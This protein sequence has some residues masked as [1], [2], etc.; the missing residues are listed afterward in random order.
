MN[1]LKKDWKSTYG[2]GHILVTVKCLLIYPNPESALDEEAGKLLLEDYNSYCERAKLITS[3]H[4]TPKVRARALLHPGPC[5]E[6]HVQVRPAEFNTPSRSDTPSEPSTSSAKPAPAAPSPATPSTST[7]PA[8][9]TSATA[10]TATT[11]SAGAAPS[12]P[13]SPPVSSSQPLHPST[14]NTY[15]TSPS[16]SSLSSEKGTS[17]PKERHVSPSPLGTADS[18]VA[19][20]VHATGGGGGGGTKAVKRAAVAAGAGGEKRKKALKRL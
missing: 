5:P 9:T 10:K 3:V 7:H 14:P 17:A 19:V 13:T 4:A 1:T 6:G 11:A 12:K 16:A 2:I 8:P 18:N 15:S 20:G